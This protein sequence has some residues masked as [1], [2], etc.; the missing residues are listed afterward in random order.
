MQ[1]TTQTIKIETLLK[2]LKFVKQVIVKNAVIPVLEEFFFVDGKIIASDLENF[3][4]YNLGAHWGTFTLPANDLIKLLSALPKGSE[5]SFNNNPE[6]NQTEILVIGTNKKFK[7]TGSSPEEFPAIPAPQKNI[8]FISSNDIEKIKSALP[9]VSK[10]NYKPAMGGIFLNGEIAS[11]DGHRLIWFQSD[12]GLKQS[13]IIPA[14]AAKLLTEEIHT[15]YYGKKDETEYVNF[16]SSE[17]SLIT[18]VINERFPDYHQAIPQNNQIKVE[19][20]KKAFIE[21]LKL[22]LL[23]TNK[24]THR[25]KLA[26]NSDL[27]ISSEDL[28]F[29]SEFSDT[30]EAKAEGTEG[31]FEIGFNGL[32]LLEFA[33]DVKEEVLSFEFSAPNRA[34]IINGNRLVMPVML[35][36]YR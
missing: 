33:E 10:D 1:T 14:K 7:L 5:I 24:T 35:T 32:F 12:K 13:F 4:V 26:I 6:T 31:L 19:V 3:I 2:A 15:V 11:T 34:A 25:V 22:A 23:A 20:S 28:D 9:F 27:Q 36:D 30:I 29:N 21:S 18:R 16:T 8:G 17:Y